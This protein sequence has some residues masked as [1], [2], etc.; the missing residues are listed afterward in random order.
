MKPRRARPWARRPDVATIRRVLART[1]QDDAIRAVLR[2][3]RAVELRDL[4][5][6]AALRA[7][8]DL[9]AARPG[10]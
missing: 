3:Q 2:D 8:H 9:M 5:L 10:A 1:E 7:T 4:R 6:E